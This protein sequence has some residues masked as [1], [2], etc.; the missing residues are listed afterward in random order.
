MR[1][2]LVENVPEFVNWGELDDAGRPIK[3]RKGQ[4]FQAWYMT[5]INLGY[6]AEWRMLNAA[7]YG[8]ATTRTR[9]FLIARKDEAPIIW[10]EPSHAKH[11][12]TL[13][14]GRLPWRG[15]KEI[16]DWSNPGRSILDDPKYRRKP[17]AANTLR[18][19]SRGLERFGGPLAPLYIR[20]LDIP[21][22]RND[23]ID[24]PESGS[25]FINAF[26]L[27]R[28]GENGSDRTHSA[29]EP[30][31]TVT[32]RGAGY[33][34][35]QTANRFIA[36]N[37]SDNAPRSV[38]QPIPPVTTANGGG[39]FLAGASARPFVLGQQSGSSPRDSD[40]PTP[41][42]S[43][44]G[45]ISL[46]RPSIILYYGQSDAQD[47]D[48]PLTSLT[49][50]GRKHGLINPTLVEYYGNSDATDL[51]QPLPTITTK[52]RYALASPA[53]LQVNH[54]NGPEGTRGD[55]RRVRSIE[56]PVPA[57]TTRH[58]L[59]IAQPV[60]LPTDHSDGT[61]EP[62]TDIDTAIRDAPKPYIVPNFGE[63]PEQQPR[64]HD[65]DEPLP[66]I[67][68][69]GAGNLVVPV[70]YRV[71]YDQLKEEGIDPRRLVF[72]DGVPHLLDIMFRMLG[73]PELARA[74][75]FDDE[76][77]QYE[78]TGNIAQITKQIGNA[79]PVRMAAALVKAIFASPP[80]PAE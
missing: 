13:M 51:D 37:R 80:N 17:L 25:T 1:C 45:A 56:E 31:P 55:N 65:I 21:D 57:I 44:A 20:L 49:S 4:Y 15:A 35:Q 70:T 34:V 23:D 16:I 24:P 38:D 52:P 27:N 30:V 22:T 54:G 72:I 5:F 14:P 26:I 47:I 3:S 7:D 68:S 10:P 19:I 67:T 11:D 69:H 40:Q 60:L 2:V 79:V 43:A 18:R 6:Q 8:D 66:T 64:I 48:T 28:H 59:A 46:V 50:K 12:G 9:F 63:R 42:I 53:L 61:H 78:F 73:N 62:A 36:A 33:L 77:Q 75:S 32:T 76:E 29:D 74:M 41:T 39:I 58:G 71:M